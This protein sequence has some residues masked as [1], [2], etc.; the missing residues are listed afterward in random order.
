VRLRDRPQA[1]DAAGFEEA[2]ATLVRLM[3]PGRRAKKCLEHVV[4]AALFFMPLPLARAL[5][6]RVQ[7]CLT[8]NRGPRR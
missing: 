8:T 1:W 3:L 7:L 6:C 5:G 2:Y 4:F